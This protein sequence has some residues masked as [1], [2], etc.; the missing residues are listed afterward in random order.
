MHPCDGHGRHATSA[1]ATEKKTAARPRLRD[2][3]EQGGEEGSPWGFGVMRGDGRKTS[4]S[5]GGL[6]G[7]FGRLERPQGDDTDGGVLRIG[8]S[9]SC[10]GAS[11]TATVSFQ[12]ANSDHTQRVQRRGFVPCKP[13]G[14]SVRSSLLFITEKGNVILPRCTMRKTRAIPRGRSCWVTMLQIRDRNPNAAQLAQTRQVL[15]YLN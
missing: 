15:D 1:V 6:P 12:P 3:A 2:G 14:F 7:R 8:D 9:C 10:A 5:S 11:T 4:R 13:Y